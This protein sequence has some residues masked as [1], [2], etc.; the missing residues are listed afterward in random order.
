LEE[1]EDEEAK[2]KE[3]AEKVKKEDV[4]QKEEVKK[5]VK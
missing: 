1:L 3:I 4:E 2:K 5:D